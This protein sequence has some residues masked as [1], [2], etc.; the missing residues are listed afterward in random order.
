VKQALTNT[1]RACSVLIGGAKSKFLWNSWATANVQDYNQDIRESGYVHVPQRIVEYATP[2]FYKD[3]P[4]LDVGSGT[5]KVGRNLWLNDM[6]VFDGVDISKGMTSRIPFGLYR[7][8]TLFNLRKLKTKRPNLPQ[9]RYHNIISS[10]VY[11][12]SIRDDSYK[13]I[14]RL[15]EDNV[16][17]AISGKDSACLDGI[18]RTMEEE[19]LTIKRSNVSF[20]YLQ[21][22][23]LGGGEL[24]NYRFLVATRGHKS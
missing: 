12:E 3:E 22:K 7:H 10:G 6:K 2:F 14:F 9:S 20:A 16:T 19:G 1:F 11:G 4:V 8:V 15:A 13:G 18:E 5:G 21:S 17:I 23:L 24:I